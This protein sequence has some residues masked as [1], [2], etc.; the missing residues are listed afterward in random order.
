MHMDNL[1]RELAECSPDAQL[2]VDVRGTIVYANAYAHEMFGYDA[3]SLYGVLIEEL[4]P[5]ESRAAHAAHRRAYATEPHIREMGTREMRLSGLRRDGTQFPAEIRLAP[6]ASEQGFVTAAVVRDAT[7]NELIKSTLTAARRGAEEANDAK[8]RFLAAASHDLRQPLQALHLIHGALKRQLAG[9]GVEE[10]IEEEGNALEGMSQLLH[11]LL[12]VAKLESGTVQPVISET[13]VRRIFED[14]RRQFSSLAATKGIRLDVDVPDCH[15]RTDRTL[16]HE[17][18]QNLLANAIRYTNV[19]HVSLRCV[20]TGDWV[21]VDVEDTGIGIPSI[22]QEKIFDD[23]YQVSAHGEEHRGGSG[24]GLGIV[25]RIAQLLGLPVR[26][27]S[28]EGTGTKFTIEIPACSAAQ[29]LQTA[30]GPQVRVST[31]RRVLVVEDEAPLQAAMKLYLKIDG[32]EVQSAGSLRELDAVLKQMQTAPDLLITDFQLGASERGSDAIE[33][34]RQR[35]GRQIPTI[36]LTG[37]T[38]A[39]PARVFSQGSVRLLNKPVDGHTLAA[40]VNDMLVAT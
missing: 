27:I 31:S 16:L 13:A 23:F 19:G 1:F 32:H 14:L 39:V 29:G 20:P 21:R 3:S 22:L 9:A 24:L 18:L 25:R 37:D 10:L 15:V 7:E 4:V 30:A 35:F 34:I 28:T 33:M 11:A 26:V 38:S 36:V 2:V 8:T 40:A 5:P 12:N 17:L 6:V